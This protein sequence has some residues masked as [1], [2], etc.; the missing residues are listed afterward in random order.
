MNEMKLNEIK[1]KEKNRNFSWNFR[2]KKCLVYLGLSNSISFQFIHSNNQSKNMS[3]IEIIYSRIQQI[4]QELELLQKQLEQLKAQEQEVKEKSKPSWKQEQDAHAMLAKF[5]RELPVPSH[6]IVPFQNFIDC[7]SF[8]ST[9]SDVKTIVWCG[10]QSW[11]VGTT[12]GEDDY[13]IYMNDYGK[14]VFVCIDSKEEFPII[15]F[16]RTPNGLGVL[17]EHMFNGALDCL[18]HP[19][20]DKPVQTTWSSYNV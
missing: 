18:E 17:A 20:L 8:V 6:Y 5:L 1:C 3:A 11:Y 7:H 15:N 4:K 16:Y 10:R 9:R 12:K 13:F 2:R 19:K 14:F